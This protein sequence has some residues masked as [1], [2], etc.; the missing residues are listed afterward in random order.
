[1]RLQSRAKQRIDRKLTLEWC[2]SVVERCSLRWAAF[3]CPAWPWGFFLW[4]RGRRRE[5]MEVYAS[6]F[7]EHRVG[8]F[9]SCES[10][11]G[12]ECGP[13]TNQ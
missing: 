4:S 5:V 13:D 10:A 11:V 3:P 2:V 8:Y 7:A 6:G 1:V 12:A 9:I